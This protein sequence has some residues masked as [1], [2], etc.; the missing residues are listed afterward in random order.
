MRLLFRNVKVIYFNLNLD[1]VANKE[2]VLSFQNQMNELSMSEYK[3]P[4][5]ALRNSNTKSSNKKHIQINSPTNNHHANS[6]SHNNQNA[7]YDMNTSSV[8]D[9]SMEFDCN[10]PNKKDANLFISHLEISKKDLGFDNSGFIENLNKDINILSSLNSLEKLDSSRSNT[11]LQN[12]DNVKLLG[13]DAKVSSCYFYWNKYKILIIVG[14]VV[15][16]VAIII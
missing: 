6:P 9:G 12:K 8:F 14:C 4:N 5:R 16:L 3:S 2:L 10:D 11:D 7:N 15:L 1:S 13:E